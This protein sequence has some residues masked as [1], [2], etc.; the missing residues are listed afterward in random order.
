MYFESLA[1]DIFSVLRKFLVF[2][3]YMPKITY[4]A[5]KSSIKSVSLKNFLAKKLLRFKEK[6]KAKISGRDYVY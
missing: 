2:L 3:L 1:P 5:E 4:N 6:R